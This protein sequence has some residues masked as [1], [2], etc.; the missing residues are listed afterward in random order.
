MDD[1][2]FLI[3][4]LHLTFKGG[5]ASASKKEFFAVLD[6]IKEYLQLAN[7]DPDIIIAGDNDAFTKDKDGKPFNPGVEKATEAAKV[8]GARLAVR[9]FSTRPRQT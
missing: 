4:S 6:W 9:A 7:H 5:D 1:F 2:D 3:L 8:V